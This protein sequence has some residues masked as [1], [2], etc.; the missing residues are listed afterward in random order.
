MAG[1]KSKLTTDVQATILKVVELG[2]PNR[3]ACLA[4]GI[5][6]GVFYFWQ[7]QAEKKRQPYLQFFEQIKEARAKGIVRHLV[8]ISKAADAGTWQASAWV[9]ERRC[10]EH[11]ALNRQEHSGNVTVTFNIPPTDPDAKSDDI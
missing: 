11:F 4:S 6:E 2:M 5:S 7:Q 9:L 8:R 1:R 10:P 3:E